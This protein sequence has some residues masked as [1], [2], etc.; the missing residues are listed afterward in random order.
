MPPPVLGRGGPVPYG[1]PYATPR[2][3]GFGSAPATP[4]P[5][6]VPPPG[7]FAVGRGGGFGSRLGNG[8]VAD[9]KHD[10]VRGGGGGGRGRGGGR[11]GPHGFRG[12]GRG[13]RS[14]GFGGRHGSSSGSS[15]DDLNNVSLPKQD[16][17]NLVPFEKNFYVESP[18]VKAMT[19]HQVMHYRASREITVQGN[20][21]PRPIR[22]FHEANFPGI[23][24]PTC[25]CSCVFVFIG[26]MTTL[27]S[28]V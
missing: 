3:N 16:F 27:A 24:P 12:S 13:G 10:I 6:F 11:A 17:R 5:H 18:S 26:M 1:A 4:V 9:R 21:V 23:F 7:G 28:F 25:L 14:A 8:H 22:A 19:D 15:R 20:D 2:P